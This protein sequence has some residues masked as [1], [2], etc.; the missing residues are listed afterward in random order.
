MSPRK[1]LVTA[2]LSLAACLL[3]APA[4][5]AV[6]AWHLSATPL[7]SS[8]TPGGEGSY[9]MVATN[10]GTTPTSGAVTLSDTLPSGLT[11]L[12]SC[13]AAGQLVTCEHLGPV[14]PGEELSDVIPVAVGSLAMGT[15]FNQA[16]VEGGGAPA[17]TLTNTTPVSATPP[18]FGFLPGF[19]APLTEPDGA[20]TTQAGSH[21]NQLTVSLGW[22]T[23][24][25]D[26][27]LVGAGHVRDAIAD[28][29]P[30]QIVNPA[31]TPVLCTAVEFFTSNC[32]PASQI[33]LISVLT[34]ISGPTT[35]TSPLYNLV[36]PAGVAS[37]FAF[38]AIGAG[39]FVH[40]LGSVRSDG[41]FGLSGATYD[42][43]AFPRNPIFGAKIQL[44]G[45]PSAAGHDQVRGTCLTKQ[46]MTVM[47]ARSHPRTPPPSPP[48]A[49][50]P[51]TR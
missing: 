4:A 27:V 19:A 49:A 36:P 25:R 6:P 34:A 30:G 32:P 43:P 26:G 44:W 1:A 12:S 29:P 23:E 22:P 2:L 47:P 7:P 11:S 35:Y 15:L 20:A 21:P 42:S 10:V 37:D 46:E 33:G 31:A 38:N 24:R 51:P 48:P 41:D 9:L 17:L 5:L 40:I 3:S 45:D 8:F 18:P 13:P 28:L 16:S 14:Y 39:I 50:A